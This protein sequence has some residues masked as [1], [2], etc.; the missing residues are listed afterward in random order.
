MSDEHEELR[1]SVRGLLSVAAPLEQVQQPEPD[2]WAG[3]WR[4]MC[5]ELDVVGLTVPEKFGGAGFG[6]AE[7]VIVAE[8][9]GRT[10][11]GGP[12][13]SSWLAAETIL[14]TG[15]EA[16]ANDLLPGI[17][18][19]STIVA[20]A[21]DVSGEGLT[22][23]A[24]ATGAWTLT[25][26]R[27]RVLDVGA[28]DLFIVTAEA[29]GDAATAVFAVEPGPGLTRVELETLDL[30]R[31]L[32]ELR[33]DD[34]PARLLGTPGMDERLP[35]VARLAVLGLAAEALGGARACVENAA[36]YGRERVQFGRPIGSFQAVKHRIADLLVDVETAAATVA[37]AAAVVAA[38][39]GPGRDLAVSVA[40]LAATGA[41]VRAAEGTIQVHG[42]IGFTWEH[43]AHLYYRR[44]AA[45]AQ[46][47]GTQD[48][49]SERV[50]VLASDPGLGASATWGAPDEDDH[51]E[52]PSYR[53]RA[54]A[55][56]TE[57]TGR[58]SPPADRGDADYGSDPEATRQA[59]TYQCALSEAGYAG[60]SWPSE[61]GG[62]GLD[63]AHERAFAAE[64]QRSGA[65]GERLFMVGLGMCGPTLLT[66]ADDDQKRRYLPPMLRGDEVW[67][68]LFSEP[69]AG[70]DLA[71]LSTRA[72]R[73][74]DGWV[75]D[76]QKVWT[77]HARVCDFGLALARTDP[78]VPK[79]R[80]ITM[81]I[82][83]LT[84][85]GVT[86]RPLRQ[87]TGEAE[88]NEVF[89]DGVRVRDADIVGGL[90]GGWRAARVML[91]N[92]R[93]SIGFHA[94]SRFDFARLT[95]LAARTGHGDD[96]VWRDRLAD[97][98]V[99]ERGLHLLSERIR[100]Q[101]AAGSDPGPI[102]SIAKLRKAELTK[103]GGHYAL[104]LAGPDAVAWAADDEAA[105][106]VVD[107]F[108]RMQQS[109]IA[110]GTDDIQRNIIGERLLGLP[111]DPQPD[112]DR[113]FRES[114]RGRGDRTG[115][116]RDG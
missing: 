83:D 22:A 15:D 37:E 50:S 80:G 96:P 71:G 89:L 97:V 39:E 59:K 14:A 13:L 31:G 60:I 4:R 5:T 29:T 102:G 48:E 36:S 65:G 72:R 47:F 104:R 92:E 62:A 114:A 23:T 66:L 111:R 98:Y 110:G 1:A 103:T 109:S 33:F 100:I 12:Y 90:G 53:Q 57:T 95:E 91:M 87:M 76:G 99:R 10:L 77:T 35:G 9:T 73:D 42:G 40:K 21:V 41:F 69:G 86:V 55:W 26:A 20:T 43:D 58:L 8:E 34:V 94:D 54:R 46:L 51:E 28:A 85:P 81:F 84:D 115:E 17:M 74:G 75:L 116:E 70:S 105:P 30:T 106:L 107:R 52:L 113:P 44:A 64:V 79:H 24:D 67:C 19:A 63:A 3:A 2:R 7:A 45:S 56:L 108:L 78:D 61:Y 27:A 32:C 112:R 18:K 6:V 88:F 93:G 101:A 68:Q 38:G 16:A 11:Y 82:V 49:H 25:G